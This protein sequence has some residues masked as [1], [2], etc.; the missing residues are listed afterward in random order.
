MSSM[1][2]KI[3][4]LIS[5]LIESLGFIYWGLELIMGGQK[6][7]L[8]VYVETE[9]GITVDQCGQVSREIGAVL[10][11][12]NVPEGEYTLEVSSPGLDRILF[13]LKQCEKYLGHEINVALISPIEGRRRYKGQLVNIQDDSIFVGDEQAQL[14]IPFHKVKRLRVVPQF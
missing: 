1:H 10:D 8:R 6:P 12:A 4:S 11:V 5:P 3:E 13:N 2:S 9:T 14:R 7:T